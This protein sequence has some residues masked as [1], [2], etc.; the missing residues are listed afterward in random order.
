MK[1]EPYYIESKDGKSNCVVRSLCKLLHKDYDKVF[2]DLVSY[3]TKLGYSSFNEIEVFEAYMKDNAIV[4]QPYGSNIK[5]GDLKL[6][7][8]AFIVFCYDHQ[9][10]YHMVCIINNVL[11][12]KS[13]D[14]KELYTISIYKMFE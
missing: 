12:D 4:K 10:Y 11:F 9:D 7:N 3:A 2:N 8:G 1:F 6:D 14:S 13:D 5:I